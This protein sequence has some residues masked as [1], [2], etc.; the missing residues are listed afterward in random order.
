LA[1]EAPREIDRSSIMPAQYGAKIGSNADAFEV[2]RTP[3]GLRSV[4][5]SSISLMLQWNAPNTS[6][7]DPPVDGYRL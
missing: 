4:F 6:Q 5:P 7:G 2:P 3:A 1:L